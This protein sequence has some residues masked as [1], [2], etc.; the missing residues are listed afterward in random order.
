MSG[1][2]SLKG[3]VFRFNRWIQKPNI[4]FALF[5]TKATGDMERTDDCPGYLFKGKRVE[6]PLVERHISETRRFL[7]I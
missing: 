2:A 1:V 5:M 7:T 4:S 6:C 3:G